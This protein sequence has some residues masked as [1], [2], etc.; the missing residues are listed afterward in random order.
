MVNEMNH[1]LE[2]L[3]HIYKN[4]EMG[5]FTT[6]TLINKIKLKENKI[7]PILEN[8]I[9]LYEDFMKKSKKIL[10][11]YDSVPKNNIMAK[12]SSSIGITMETIK[13][14]SDSAL[15]QMLVEGMSMGVVS[16]TTKISQYIKVAD[17]KVI[18][19]AKNFQKFQEEEIDKLKAYM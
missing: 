18:K 14:N 15:A 11:S 16:I 19:L 1:N 12:L 6:T 2:L 10:K 4:S 7:K 3:T 17:K 13:D 9:K 5:V 8:E